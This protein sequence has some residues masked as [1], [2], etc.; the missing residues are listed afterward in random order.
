MPLLITQDDFRPLLE[1]THFFAELFQVIRDSLL[2]QD[3]S[4]PG[5]LSWLAFP[6][7]QEERRFNVNL[8]ATSSQGTSIRVFPVSGGEIHPAQ[9][10]F[11]AFLI[12]NHDGRLQALLA[13]DDLSPLRTSAPVGLACM[14]LARP[15]AETLAILGSGQQA[16]YHLRAICPA[17]PSLSHV[18]VFSPT[19][20]HRQQYAAEM[21]VQTGIRVEA[22]KSARE[23][24][25]G[26]DLVCI[27]SAGRGPMLEAA[28]VRP[29]AL[30]ISI[31]GQGLPPDLS[32]RVVVPALAGPVVRPSGWDPRP[33]MAATGGRDPSTI[34]ATLVDVLRGTARAR[35][36]EDDIVLYEQRGSYSWDAALLRW[37]Y[38]WALEHQVGTSFQLTSRQ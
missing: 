31:T 3:Q 35:Q 27:A 22:V 6:L 11:F 15:R 10:G 23:A 25:E 1:G 14:H 32:T 28:W 5:Y 16:R 33:V 19:A 29:G 30:L 18:R 21:S 20:E 2:S 26:A 8:L 7:G 37:A 13:T 9:D 4:D 12:D 24:V 17:L 34:A 38:N 36:H